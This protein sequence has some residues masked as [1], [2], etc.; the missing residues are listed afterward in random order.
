MTDSHNRLLFSSFLS[1]LGVGCLIWITAC[2]TVSNQTSWIQVGKTTK[3]EVV[4]RYGEPD[5]VQRSSDGSVET[6][7]PTASKHSSP[8]VEIP[9]VQPGP[10]GT[11]TTTMKPIEPGLGAED[12]TTGRHEWIRKEIRLRYDAQGIVQEVLE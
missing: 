8:R 2:A 11:T 5:L 7:R 6:Y 1:C 4:T 10:L 9:T 3:T 12:V